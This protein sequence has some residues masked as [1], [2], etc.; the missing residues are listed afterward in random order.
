MVRLFGKYLF[1]RPLRQ[2]LR[3]LLRR[4]VLV[5][6]LAPLIP[7]STGGPLLE[8]WSE[9]VWVMD[10]ARWEYMYLV[11]VCC[12]VHIRVLCSDLPVPVPA[13]AVLSLFRVRCNDVLYMVEYDSRWFACL[14]VATHAEGN[15]TGWNLAHCVLEPERKPEIITQPSRSTPWPHPPSRSLHESIAYWLRRLTGVDVGVE[16]DM[17]GRRGV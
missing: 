15:E 13:F 1:L 8:L 17:Q 10:L 4:T 12:T 6:R 3:R 5:L 2:T 11:I 14:R 7:L 16:V 9:L